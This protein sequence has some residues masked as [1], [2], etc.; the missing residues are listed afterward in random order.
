MMKIIE[1]LASKKVYYSNRKNGTQGVE[2]DKVKDNHLWLKSTEADNTLT[3]NDLTEY[4]DL[5][6]YVTDTVDNLLD[7][8]LEIEFFKDGVILK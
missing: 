5:D 6:I 2:F 3:L 8:V 7:I 4:K 1:V